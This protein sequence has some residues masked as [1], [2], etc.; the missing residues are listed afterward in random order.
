MPRRIRCTAPPLP[1]VSLPRP[2]SNL[3]LL[4]PLPLQANRF[5]PTDPFNVTDPNPNYDSRVPPLTGKPSVEREITMSR[6]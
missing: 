6:E 3:P 5:F 4:T 1:P 2:A